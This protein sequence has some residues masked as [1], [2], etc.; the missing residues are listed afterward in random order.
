MANFRPKIGQDATFAPTLNEHNSAIFYPILTFDHTKFISL[1]IMICQNKPNNLRKRKLWKMSRL[2]TSLGFKRTNLKM[3]RV[4]TPAFP[5]VPIDR[6]C[7]IKARPVRHLNLQVVSQS[8][9]WPTIEPR[10]IIAT[11]TRLIPIKAIWRLK[12]RN[13]RNSGCPSSTRRYPALISNK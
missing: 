4:P 13:R 9:T 8:C 1:A 11:R 2:L 7:K 5:S 12:R 6:C 3:M 10:Q